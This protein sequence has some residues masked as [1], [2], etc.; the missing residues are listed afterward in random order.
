M[1]ANMFVAMALLLVVSFTAFGGGYH[2]VACTKA[3]PKKCKTTYITKK[4][5]KVINKVKVVNNYIT[6][7][8][9]SPAI[10]ALRKAQAVSQAK[11]TIPFRDDGLS[12]GIGAARAEGSDGFAVGIGYAKDKVK[13]ILSV[14]D[15]GSVSGGVSLKF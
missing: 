6:Q 14:G 15:D 9:Y 8:D 13:G 2:P 1:K 11:S 7:I 12:I 3:N 10:R 4:K 5:V